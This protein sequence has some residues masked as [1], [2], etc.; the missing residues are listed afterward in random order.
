MNEELTGKIKAVVDSENLDAQISYFSNLLSVA[1]EIGEEATCAYL[2]PI[3]ADIVPKLDDEVLAVVAESLAELDLVVTQ[4]HTHALV[5][6]I[7]ALLESEENAVKQRVVSS[8]EA[9]IKENSL[10]ACFFSDIFAEI[11]KLFSSP[12]FTQKETALLLVG[13]AY[14][15]LQL[16]QKEKIRGRLLALAHDKNTIVKRTLGKTVTD[17]IPFLAQEDIEKTALPVAAVLSEN[18]QDVLRLASVNILLAAIQNTKTPEAVK[19]AEQ[20]VERLRK[21]PSWRVRYQAA[22]R[23]DEYIGAFLEEG[24]LPAEKAHLVAS[25]VSFSRDTETEVRVAAAGRLKNVALLC[26]PLLVCSELV[27]VSK[28]LA[29]DGMHVVRGE[30]AKSIGTLSLIIGKEAAFQSL[31]A[32]FIQ[33]L[34]DEYADVRLSLIASLRELN[35]VF[36]LDAIEE[37]L[38]LALDKL[39]KDKQWRVRKETVDVVS[40]VLE[41]CSRDYFEAK[42]NP[43]CMNWLL[44]PVHSVRAS[45]VC[46]VKKLFETFGEDWGIR[47]ILPEINSLTKN[48]IYS[49]RQSALYAY[50]KI[51]EAVSEKTAADLLFP[52]VASS[53]YDTVP[54]VRLVAAKVL[55]CFGTRAGKAPSVQPEL[56]RVLDFLSTD[57]NIDVSL[58]AKEALR[59]VCSLSLSEKASC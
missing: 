20:I 30:I 36:G 17:I 23:W 11:E 38:L 15:K 4:Q 10:S 7:V 32:V 8:L 54:N 24:V 18:D 55:A 6:V 31:G 47:V 56:L 22:K 53:A 28:T 1:R 41:T 27:A 45:A 3:L 14:K 58:R 46:C 29:S 42:L 26:P 5:P 40:V 39:S 52:M 34:E 9:L 16:P 13:P 59:T 37:H 19:T 50:G 12:Y 51:K 48:K 33:L 57:E 2:L 49:V 25:F 43:F 44:D 21:D 35:G